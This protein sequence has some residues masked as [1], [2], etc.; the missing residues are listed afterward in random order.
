[1]SLTGSCFSSE[2]APGPFHRG[3]SIDAVHDHGQPT[4]QGHDRLFYPAAP[5]DLHGVVLHRLYRYRFCLTRLTLLSEVVVDQIDHHAVKAGS[6]LV[7][8]RLCHESF[9]LSAQE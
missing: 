2:W 3:R 5:G 4:C 6:F 7:I 8:L 9:S 1:M